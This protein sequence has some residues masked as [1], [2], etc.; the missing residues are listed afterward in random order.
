[1]VKFRSILLSVIC[2]VMVSACGALGPNGFGT[3]QGYAGIN[4][5]KV[6]W[7]QGDDGR[8]SPETVHIMNGKEQ[9]M[10]DLKFEMPDGTIVNYKAGDVKAFEGQEIRGMVDKAFSDQMGNIMPDIVDAVITAI[11]KGPPIP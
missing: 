7:A 11:K 1:M 9:S 3:P 10:V 4:S 2:M 6:S 8:W 5:I